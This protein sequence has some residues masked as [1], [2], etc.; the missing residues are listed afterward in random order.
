MTSAAAFV[1]YGCVFV[2]GDAGSVNLGEMDGVVAGSGA[3]V[4]GP[5]AGDVTEDFCF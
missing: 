1:T 3:D 5:A 4:Q 2:A